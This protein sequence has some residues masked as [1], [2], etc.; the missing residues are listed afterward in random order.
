MSEEQAGQG[1]RRQRSNPPRDPVARR[2]RH[3]RYAAGQAIAAYRYRVPLVAIRINASAD[4]GEVDLWP[5]VAPTHDY[6]WGRIVVCLAG[7]EAVEACEH[8]E[9][10]PIDAL[11]DSWWNYAPPMTRMT[12]QTDDLLAWH[13]IQAIHAPLRARRNDLYRGTRQQAYA[14]FLDPAN[15]AAVDVLA[16]HLQERVDITGMETSAIIG[17][18]IARRARPLSDQP[19]RHP[20]LQ[21]VQDDAA[22]LPQ[23]VQ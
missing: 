12:E 7:R 9:H 17:S 21:P 6:L 4:R 1:D 10:P 15:R 8:A 16:R 22:P 3:A 11:P 18:V 19:T 20:H 2:E 13:I 23:A 14:L 5:V